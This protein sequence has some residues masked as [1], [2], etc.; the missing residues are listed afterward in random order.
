MNDIIY[1]NSSTVPVVGMGA[2]LCYVTDTHPYTIVRVID[3]KTIEVVEDEYKVVKGNTHDGSAEYE[4]SPG[5]GKS[6][7]Y[8]LRRNGKWVR[9]GESSAKGCTRLLPGIRRKYY[10]PH[11]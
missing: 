4:Y 5:K 3:V 10:D 6:E 8:T 9:Q 1:P 2:T 7:I 11:F